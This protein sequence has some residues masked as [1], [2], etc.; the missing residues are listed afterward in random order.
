M[1]RK[2]SSFLSKKG[3]LW[4]ERN[5]KKKI[6]VNIGRDMYMFTEASFSGGI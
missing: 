4:G 1:L 3:G 6:A 5:V 2:H